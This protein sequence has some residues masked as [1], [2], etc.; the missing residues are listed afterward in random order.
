MELREVSEDALLEMARP[1][2][3]ARTTRQSRKPSTHLRPLP[4]WLTMWRKDF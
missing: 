3:C 2:P 4:A 1:N